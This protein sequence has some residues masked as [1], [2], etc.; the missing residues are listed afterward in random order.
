MTL[1]LFQ[2]IFVYSETDLDDNIRN[3]EK[4]KDS[5]III[6]R[7][8]NV[9][10]IEMP[11]IEDRQQATSVKY[12][13]LYP[14]KVYYEE[15]QKKKYQY[16]DNYG[17]IHMNEVLQVNL[18]GKNKNN[19]VVSH[20]H[21][22]N[23][24]I[25]YSPIIFSLQDNQMK[26]YIPKDNVNFS[27]LW[28]KVN[29]Y[30]FNEGHFS[31]YKPIGKIDDDNKFQMLSSVYL[32]NMEEVQN[33][34]SL[35]KT[36]SSIETND[37]AME[38]LFEDQW[39]SF[40][41]SFN[42]FTP[43]INNIEINNNYCTGYIRNE[44]GNIIFIKE[45]YILMRCDNH[46]N[47]KYIMK[48]KKN[49]Y[50]DYCEIIPLKQQTM[51]FFFPKKN[52]VSKKNIFLHK[53]KQIQYLKTN[54]YN[55]NQYI[56]EFLP[57]SN[58]SLGKIMY[59]GSKFDPS[60][61]IQDECIVIVEE[62][63]KSNKTFQNFKESHIYQEIIGNHE[64]LKLT[65]KKINKKRPLMINND[66]THI[67]DALKTFNLESSNNI[68]HR[69]LH[70]FLSQCPYGGF[71]DDEINNFSNQLNHYNVKCIVVWEFQDFKQPETVYQYLF[72][73][74]S[75]RCNLKYVHNVINSEDQ[76]N[77]IDI[78]YAFNSFSSISDLKYE[79]RPDTFSRI[80]DLKYDNR[81]DWSNSFK[82]E[83]MSTK[84]YFIT[85]NQKQISKK[86]IEIQLILYSYSNVRKNHGYEKIWKYSN[87][88][89]SN[90]FMDLNSKNFGIGYQFNP[91]K[92]QQCNKVKDFYKVFI[93]SKSNLPDNIERIK[94]VLLSTQHGLPKVTGL[95]ISDFKNLS[96][97]YFNSL[98]V[99]PFKYHKVC[100]KIL[101][102]KNGYAYIQYC[103]DNK[104][105]CS[106]KLNNSIIN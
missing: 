1:I 23:Q 43:T 83:N 6:N 60:K 102:D 68:R 49:I 17:Y 25:S 52:Q 42:Q 27:I 87:K 50:K 14:C 46:W 2:S 96:L 99:R 89:F 81:P 7:N 51:Y 30:F 3:Y 48:Y 73:K 62:S 61:L 86:I 56:F 45:N 78:P 92:C 8:Q 11:S 95:N 36:F 82:H 105:I 79:N 20:I 85:N 55:S 80:S 97:F 91:E 94:F 57:S 24:K 34:Q 38:T 70:F 72:K 54:V 40:I 5:A 4:E 90:R 66:P 88:I 53:N 59:M 65:G 44:N 106:E 104:S 19:Y 101:Y 63:N 35:S 58:K 37:F 67:I 33:Y 71:G 15:N 77:I 26:Y 76:F 16:F 103:G 69:Q 100:D 12:N 21:S 98:A 64:I 93:W 32:L 75:D 39:K 74:I 10:N 31:A 47:L 41:K 13:E 18:N 29:T 9:N 84:Y 28:E 22:N